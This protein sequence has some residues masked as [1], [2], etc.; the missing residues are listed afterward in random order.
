MTPSPLAFV[1]AHPG[2]ELRVHHW[3][4]SKRPVVHVLTDGSGS[5]GRSRIPSTARVL[6]AAGARTGGC[7]GRFTDREL[8]GLLLERRFD[9]FRA[10]ALA[11]ADEL[12]RDGVE[13]V[14]GDAIEGFNPGH[15][16]TRIL[17]NAAVRL[18]RAGGRVVANLEFDVE[19]APGSCGDGDEAPFRLHLGDEAFSRKIAAASGYDEMGAEVARLLGQHGEWQFRCECLRPAGPSLAALASLPRP[20]SYEAHGERRVAAGIYDRVVRL[21]EHLLPLARDLDALA[22]EAP[23]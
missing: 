4:E 18:L 5:Q 17:L 21:E 11:L 2:H 7:F 22:H 9:V 12:V 19:A 14:A 3:I 20:V 8:Y 13:V 6:A 16:A 15:D 10:A 23:R 1:F